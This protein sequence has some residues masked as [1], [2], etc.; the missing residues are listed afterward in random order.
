MFQHFEARTRRHIGA[1]QEYCIRLEQRVPGMDGL[2]TRSLSHDA[3]KFAAPEHIPYV[4]LTW[5]YKRKDDGVSLALPPGVE[6]QIVAATEHHIL[7]N[8]HHPE[9]HGARREH[10]INTR[11]RD[12]PPKEQV[13]ATGMGPWDL[14]EMVADWAAM[15]DERGNTAR[16]WADQ[17]VNVRWRF[18]PQ[19]VAL[20]D[21]LIAAAQP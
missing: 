15:G 20:I 4:W 11:D 12:K 17:N 9:A 13:D 5:R 2:A 3:S 18:T 6:A 1:V 14:A 19:Q 21:H 10:L 7:A 8:S 16:A